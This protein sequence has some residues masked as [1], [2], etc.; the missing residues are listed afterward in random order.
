MRGRTAISSCKNPAIAMWIQQKRGRPLLCGYDP[1]CCKWGGGPFPLPCC[2]I[3]PLPL[4]SPHQKVGAKWIIHEERNTAVFDFRKYNIFVKILKKND[5]KKCKKKKISQ[6][7]QCHQYHRHFVYFYFFQRVINDIL[8]RYHR[9]LHH[10]RCHF[11][12]FCYLDHAYLVYVYRHIYLLSL[13]MHVVHFL[14]ILQSIVFL[15]VF[16]HFFVF[17]FFFYVFSVFFVF[18]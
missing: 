1:S 18:V 12:F 10:L 9:L 6:C 7:H 15:Y 14:F 3:P 16:I 4:P 11:H 5:K 17:I 13:S 2:S 8:L